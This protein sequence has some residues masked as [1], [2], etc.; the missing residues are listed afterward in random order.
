ME[1]VGVQV[2]LR[3]CVVRDHGALRIGL[4]AQLTADFEPGLGGGRGN[5][6]HDH[7]VANQRF[8]TPVLAKVREQTMLDLVPLAGARRQMTYGDRQTGFVGQLLEFDFPQHADH[9]YLLHD[10]QTYLYYHRGEQLTGYGYFGKATGPIALLDEA[11]FPAVLARAETEADA[12]HDD[13]FGMQLPLVNR[14]AVDHLLGQGF[15][16]EPF[17]VL[18]MS[19]APFG[20]FETYIVSSPPFRRLLLPLATREP[21]HLRK[22]ADPGQVVGLHGAVVGEVDPGLAVAAAQLF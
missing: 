4:R 3:Q 13:E 9:E 18:F 7:F 2:D 12:R 14:A 15:Q 22:V 6:V 16:L 1:I 8:A 20:K 21:D 5:Q 17:T 11:D 19:D 10:R